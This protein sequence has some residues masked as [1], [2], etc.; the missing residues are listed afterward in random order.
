MMMHKLRSIAAM[1]AFWLL[2]ASK[3]VLPLLYGE[4]SSDCAPYDGPAFVITLP[5]P[6]QRGPFW[7]LRANVPL[8]EIAGH[9][10][11]SSTGQPG[12]A[13][14]ALCQKTPTHKCDMPEEGSFTV[15]GHPGA[16]I[17]GTIA[18]TFTDGIRHV[19]RFTAA[20][21]RHTEGR[22]CG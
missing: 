3:P 5:A 10:T 12:A 7:W 17:K 2:S 21:A 8:A 1:A 6:V 13:S 15:T 11:H 19:Y 9:W 22:L 4:Y 18:A 14:I 20:T 16:N